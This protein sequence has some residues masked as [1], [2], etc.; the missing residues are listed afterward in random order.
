M[1][2]TATTQMRGEVQPARQLV[3]AEDPQADERRLEEEGQQALE[4]ER[5][6]EDVADEPRVGR[7]VH[8]ELE[9]LHDAGDDAHREVDQEDLA[10]ELRQLQVVRACRCGTRPS[11]RWRRCSDHARSSAAR[12]GSGRSV[13]SPNCQRA[14]SSG[15]SHSF[16]GVPS[17][18][19]FYSCVEAELLHSV[20]HSQPARATLDPWRISEN[21]SGRSWTPLW[22]GDAPITASELRDKLTAARGDG[23]TPAL[24]T[25]LTVLSRLEQKGFVDATGM[26]DR[27]CTPPPSP[28]PATSPTSCTKCSSPPPTAPRRS[29]TS[30]DPSTSPRPRCCAAC[31]TRAAC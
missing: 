15:S 24:T 29:P 10:E 5:R 4:R 2:P 20:E 19:D 28:A 3:P 1:L 17:P 13:V 21:S 12:T 7:P 25:V 8:A 16:T 30:S 23:K 14:S 9:L 27:T 26:R 18:I 11:G 31:S 6:A 22:D